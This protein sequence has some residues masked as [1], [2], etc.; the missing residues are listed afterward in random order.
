M[1]RYGASPSVAASAIDERIRMLKKLLIPEGLFRAVMWLVSLVFA[2]FL[3][4]LGGRIIADL[5]RLET[6]LTVERFADK[7][8]LESVRADIKA[9][10]TRE[11]DTADRRQQA[12]LRLTA[13]SNAY[14]SARAAYSNWIA[15]RTATT[16]PSQDAE[17]V[18]RTQELDRL[19]ASE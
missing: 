15:T 4:G 7:A 18:R 14:E 8:P 17:V 19:K 12:Q 2:G 1:K 11:R 6:E 3:I 16:D 10:V 9:A 13:V 5:P